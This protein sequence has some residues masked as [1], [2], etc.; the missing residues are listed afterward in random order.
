MKKLR[1]R[2]STVNITYIYGDNG[3]GAHCCSG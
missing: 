2:I 3:N 1:K